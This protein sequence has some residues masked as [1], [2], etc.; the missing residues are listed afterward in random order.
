M[1][2]VVQSVAAE[3]ASAAPPMSLGESLARK[4]DTVGLLLRRW[5]G[6]WIDLLVL[7]GWVMGLALSGEGLEGAGV[8]WRFTAFTLIAGVAVYYPVC[9]GAWGRTLGKLVAGTIVVD[10]S[11]NTPALWRVIVRTL[12]RLVEVNPFLVGGVPAGIVAALMPT[13]QRVGDL[14]AGTYVVRVDDLRTAKAASSFA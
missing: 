13:R 1:T 4:G 3:P 14:L 8:P 5:L 6:C 10:A 2:D 9:E 12:T 7:A 11:G